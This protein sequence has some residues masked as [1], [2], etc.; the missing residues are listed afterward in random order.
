MADP[1]YTA[2]R[3]CV[4]CGTDFQ[5][6]SRSQGRPRQRCFEC[7]PPRPGQ[8]TP[9]GVGKGRYPHKRCRCSQCDHIFLSRKA[10][11]RF[12]G[13][14]CSRRARKNSRPWEE[15]VALRREASPL[16]RD[17]LCEGC[18]CT[19]RPKRSERRRFCSREC[20]FKNPAIADPLRAQRV[21]DRRRTWPHSKV[22]FHTC[23][24]CDTV[25]AARHGNQRRCDADC[26]PPPPKS[27]CAHCGR[28]FEV[29]H[30]RKVCSVAC[31]RAKTRARVRL[32][33]RARE[34]RRASRKAGKLRRRTAV[35]ETVNAITVFNRDGWRC[36]LCGVSTPQRLRGTF[37][38][39]APELD[40]IIPIA[41]GGEHSY[42]N[43]QCACRQCNGTKGDREL[44]QL[45]LFG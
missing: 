2:A 13:A 32:D 30:G 14:T 36:Q 35:V 28:T 8:H 37:E 17:H 20:A 33:P 43:T 15:A 10:T 19:F 5:L 9:S 34:R 29:T 18:G 23:V 12:C 31:S 1:A 26:R 25:F 4:E 24:A 22:W 3:A 11:A 45:R 6:Q 42:R 16:S 38:P 7:S 40:H 21:S 39:R 27:E 41:K 44:G